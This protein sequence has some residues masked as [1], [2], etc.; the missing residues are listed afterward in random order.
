[1]YGMSGILFQQRL[2]QVVKVGILI[3]Q[4]PLTL[5]LVLGDHLKTLVS[6]AG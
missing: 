1:M 5:R 3:T 6:V 2:K 4:L